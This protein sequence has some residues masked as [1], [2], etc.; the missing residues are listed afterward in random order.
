MLVGPM[1]TDRLA[2]LLAEA[3]GLERASRLDGPRL[4]VLGVF[5]HLLPE[6]G[7][8]PGTTTQVTGI[9]ATTLALSLV[10][11]AS[12]TSWTATVGMPSLGLRAAAELGVDLDH[13][14]VV[15]DPGKRWTDVLSAVVD[16]FDVVLAYPPPSRDAR[17]IV[18]RVRERDAALVVVGPFDG[19]DVR[20]EGAS[21]SWHGLEQGHGHLTARAVEVTVV[22]RRSASRMRRATIWL[23][24]EDGEVSL[25][26]RNVVQL[27]R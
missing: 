9:G 6:G 21:A 22:G 1:A 24:D 26:R 11:V 15:P 2:A 3:P 8:R 18:G 13:L 23:P 14:V 10:S 27:A 20:L 19:S 25:V 4:P 7:L 16:A 12:Q 5:E 17:K